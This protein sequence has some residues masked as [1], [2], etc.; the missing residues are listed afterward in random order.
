MAA[1]VFTGGN[2]TVVMNPPPVVYVQVFYSNS[3]P[4][5]FLKRRAHAVANT[6]RAIAPEGETGR[7][8]GS[9]RV[10]QNRNEKGQF[11][12]GYKVY[13]NARYARYVHEGTGPSVRTV[14]P[15]KMVF[16]GTNG[17]KGSIIRTHVVHHP[18]TPKNPFL[19]KS[20]TA[21]AR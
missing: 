12:F 19:T 20:L 21:M 7:L 4:D 8:K 10:D 11:A 18:G 16:A 2:A 15:H 17:Y 5:R 14:E 1:G 9:I 3:E 6:A 13:S